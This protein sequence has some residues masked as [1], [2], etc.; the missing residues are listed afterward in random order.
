MA[1]IKIERT[2]DDERSNLARVNEA[3][4]LIEII[5]FEDLDAKEMNFVGSIMSKLNFSK[6]ATRIT[7]K[8]IFYLRDIKDK[9]L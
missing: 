6:S 4:R 2:I 9:H 7:E 1:L 3:M 8:Q 5:N